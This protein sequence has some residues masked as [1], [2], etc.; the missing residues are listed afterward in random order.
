MEVSGIL[1]PLLLLPR[2]I[3]AANLLGYS[4]YPVDA[5]GLQASPVPMRSNTATSLSILP[6][7]WSIAPDAS[8]TNMSR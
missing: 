3:E 7:R 5:S 8:G 1:I 2:V 6:L 4:L